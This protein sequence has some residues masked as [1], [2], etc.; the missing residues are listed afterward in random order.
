MPIFILKN[1]RKTL[2]G[3]AIPDLQQLTHNVPQNV[4]EAFMLLETSNKTVGLRT[5]ILGMP[6]R[7]YPNQD[8]VTSH[9]S[10]DN[11]FRCGC[12]RL[13]EK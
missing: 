2:A 5:Q 6:V 8:H 9:G 3:R 11:K 13:I 4:I 1:V 10:P 7:L 12:S